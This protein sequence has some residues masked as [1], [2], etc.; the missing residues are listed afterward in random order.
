[1]NIQCQDQYYTSQ[2]T[3]HTENDDDCGT[4][5]NQVRIRRKERKINQKWKNYKTNTILQSANCSELDVL[6][7]IK[8]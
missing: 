3:H 2:D 5:K 8:E 7:A 6:Y 1:M 4:G